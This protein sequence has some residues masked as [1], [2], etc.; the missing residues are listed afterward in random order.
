M[1]NKNNNIYLN[2]GNQSAPSY[3][4]NAAA[5]MMMF[6]SNI[7]KPG[8][9]GKTTF[10]DIL[11]DIAT[12]L[13]TAFSSD[14]GGLYKGLAAGLGHANSRRYYNYLNDAINTDQANKQNLAN[15][16]S[17]VYKASGIQGLPS[18]APIGFDPESIQGAVDW[19]GNT[20]TS[21]VL[22]DAFNNHYIDPNATYTGVDPSKVQGMAE[23]LNPRNL[24]VLDSQQ[25]PQSYQGGVQ[26]YQ[27]N[28]AGG[29]TAQGLP[30]PV[31]QSSNLQPTQAQP[32]IL[33]TGQNNQS[34]TGNVQANNILPSPPPVVGGTQPFG[35]GG[36]TDKD[37]YTQGTNQA[38]DRQFEGPLKNAQ[39]RE[40]IEGQIP[41]LGAKKTESLSHADLMKRTDPN[42][43]S[44]GGGGTD[45]SLIDA[46]YGGMVENL[47]SNN[48][49]RINELTSQYTQL[50][51]SGDITMKEPGKEWYGLGG[52]I[53]DPKYN[54]GQEIQSKIQNLQNA[55]ALLMQK[56][57]NYIPG[58]V[59]SGVGKQLLPQGQIGSGLQIKTPTISGGGNTADSYLRKKGL[60]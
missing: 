40:I 17:G 6:P 54:M 41:L 1:A 49:S 45:P 35:W 34:F 47:I 24:A 8:H 19:Q 27:N 2:A 5:G 32:G 51:K 50:L 52:Q 58:G 18:T 14:S 10:L 33:D 37:L 60:R 53:N 11:G 13:G 4:S 55:N 39:T 59:T 12:G 57:N 3:I 31:M 15:A 38:Y 20:N 43:R 26:G 23:L 21:K 42:I 29:V 9:P 30:A 48:N 28:L 16:Y 25:Y 46:R 44:G 7:G 22:A 36:V 56:L